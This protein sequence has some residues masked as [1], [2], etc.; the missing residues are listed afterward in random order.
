MHRVLDEHELAVEAAVT[1]D[2][3]TLL[4]AFLASMVTVSIPDAK[5]CMEEMLKKEKAYLPKKWQK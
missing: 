5:A 1:C 3:K 2:R 4:K